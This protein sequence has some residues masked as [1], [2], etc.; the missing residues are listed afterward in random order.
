MIIIKILNSLRNEIFKKFK[1]D[2]L[3]VLSLI[4]ELEN[5][6]NKGKILG[7]VGNFSIRELK[8]QSF[9]FYFILDSYKLYLFNK[10]ELAELLIKFVKMSKKNNQQKTIEE[11]KK[12][13]NAIGV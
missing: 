4:E 12:I 2:S 11:I 13:L 1:H 6:P 9:R 5:N 3:K 8:Y 10:K 7:K